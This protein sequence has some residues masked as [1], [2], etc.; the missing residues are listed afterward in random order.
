MYENMRNK[1]RFKKRHQAKFIIIKN[2]INN[3]P[4]Y[5]W[6][7]TKIRYWLPF[8]GISF[9]GGVSKILGV[10]GTGTLLWIHDYRQI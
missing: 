8:K 4:D 3:I 2:I 6:V 5:V 1:I 7:K 9:V 10:V